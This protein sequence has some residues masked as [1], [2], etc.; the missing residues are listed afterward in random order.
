MLHDAAAAPAQPLA[1]DVR[2]GGR[3]VGLLAMWAAAMR[4]TYMQHQGDGRRGEGGGGGD[5]LGFAT[6]GVGSGCGREGEAT[7]RQGGDAWPDASLCDTLDAP[8]CDTL[9][10]T[11]ASTHSRFMFG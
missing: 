10:S 11:L 8:L 7:P 9:A 2:V 5:A 1:R 6:G 4:D 3:G